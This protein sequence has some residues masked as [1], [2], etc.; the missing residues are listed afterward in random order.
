MQRPQKWGKA[1][2]LENPPAGPPMH[3]APLLMPK[4]MP[5]KGPH[6][7]SMADFTGSMRCVWL[8][9]I[10]TVGSS[11][12]DSEVT[13]QWRFKNWYVGRTRE[14]LYMYMLIIIII[15]IIIFWPRVYKT[16]GGSKITKV[17]KDLF[18][19][20]PYFGRSSSIKPSCSKTELSLL[21]LLLVGGV[22]QW[23]G[24]RSVAGGLSLICA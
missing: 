19:S 20:T 5:Y 16:S 8:L 3:L 15:T 13:T 14:A 18:S 23:L 24:C 17:D 10:L 7:H 21:L 11:A 22:A 6:T 4:I 9:S 1:L 2:P 12:S